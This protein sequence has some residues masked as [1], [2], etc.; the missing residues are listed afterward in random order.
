AEE[1]AQNEEPVA[2]G[3][4]MDHNQFLDDPYED[5]EQSYDTDS[6]GGDIESGEEDNV[7]EEG[8]T[9]VN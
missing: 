7:A 2:S 1:V 6:E 9:A 4:V 3:H 5:E 8:E